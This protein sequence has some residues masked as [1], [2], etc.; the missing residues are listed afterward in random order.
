MEAP[1]FTVN[2]A[3]EFGPC[4][5]TGICYPHATEARSYLLKR[6]KLCSFGEGSNKFS[7]CRDMKREN[8]AGS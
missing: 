1:L 8:W 7:P 5:L 2:I 3:F 4:V 6:D